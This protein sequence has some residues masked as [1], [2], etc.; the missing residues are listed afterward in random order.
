[1]KYE[2]KY[3]EIPGG[4]HKGYVDEQGRLV[5]TDRY[6]WFQGAISRIH[7][8]L[9]LAWD[10]TMGRWCLA[11]QDKI[12]RRGVVPGVD[13]N[14]GYY[15]TQTTIVYDICWAVRDDKN[16]IRKYYREPSESI[17]AQIGRMKRAA[18][19]WDNS[20]HMA[21]ESMAITDMKEAD[22]D[23]RVNED[24]EGRME[25]V[26]VH[27]DT[28]SSTPEKRIRSAVPETYEVAT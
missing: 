21:G 8:S 28:S 1:M 17:L 23:Q 11:R 4:V 26:A 13:I 10:R 25:E 16:R 7:G 18:F 9:F 5:W 20:E 19:E 12:A 14:L 24:V 6:E 22:L 2:P 27:L 3:H 15:D